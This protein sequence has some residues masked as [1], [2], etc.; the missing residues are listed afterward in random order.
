M[1][2]LI[3]LEKSLFLTPFQICCSVASVASVWSSFTA[4][5]APIARSMFFLVVFLSRASWYLSFFILI[6]LI[7]L[8]A[9]DWVI[10]ASF[11]PCILRFSFTWVSMMSGSFFFR[12]ISA[13]L[14]AFSFP[15]MP[16]WPLTQ[17][18]SF[19]LDFGKVL[20]EGVYCI[21]RIC[22]YVERWAKFVW[23]S[24]RSVPFVVVSE[25]DS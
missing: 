12:P 5:V 14:S 18:E 24:D 1:K 2:Y 20:R 21:H 3:L 22:V 16:E 7:I 11:A 4:S 10:V 23:Y 19:V 6:F 9:R 13:N 15:S 25:E 17:E 8:Y